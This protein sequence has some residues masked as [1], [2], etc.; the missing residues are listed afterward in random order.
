MVNATTAHKQWSTRPDDQRFLSLAELHDAVSLRRQQSW[1]AMPPLSGIQVIPEGEEI[2]LGIHDRTRGVDTRLLPTNWAMGQLCSAAGVPKDFIQKIDPQ[3]AAINLMYGMRHL[4]TRTDGLLY[5]QTMD[6]G[7]EYARALTSQTYGRIYDIEVVEAVERVNQECG[8]I[9]QIPAASYANSNPRRATTL[10]ASDRDV[11]I[12]LV[13]PE[14]SIDVGG[15]TLFR[16]F[17]ASNSEVGAA[18][19]SLS[20][21]LFRRVC[22]NRII[23]GMTG[24]QEMKIRHTSGAPDRFAYEGARYLQQ[25][26]NESTVQTVRQI[27]AAQKFELPR[28]KD[29][30]K[31]GDDNVVD[32]LKNLGFTNEQS[33]SAVDFANIEEGQAS[34][35]WD[36]VNGMTAYAR[37]IPFQDQRVALESKAGNLISRFASV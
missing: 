17:I 12:F 31:S 18:T 29:T 37:K 3:L 9:W 19:F 36:I 32:W 30:S 34:S 27:E 4:A 7:A 33:K 8:N 20:T 16:G 14:K 26:S 13:D 15:D 35:L 25:Y 1:T 24:V 10:Y 11:F 6:D 22:D 28:K 2:V 23:W 21:F 5:A